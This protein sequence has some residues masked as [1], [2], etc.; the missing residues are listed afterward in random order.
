MKILYVSAIEGGKHTGPYYSVPNQIGAQEK[1]DQI[2]WVN[3]TD[4]NK[5]NLLRKDLYHQKSIRTFDIDKL[6]KPFNNPDLVV[7][8]EFFKIPNALFARK[9]VRKQIPYVIIPRSQM[10][11]QY[12][13]HKRFKKQIASVAL[14]HTFAKKA[15][16]VQFL[17]DKEL[18]D[19]KKFYDGKSFVVPNGIYLPDINVSNYTTNNN[20]YTGT[21][22]G[23]Y[24]I[25]QKGLDLL[26]EAVNL[27]RDNLKNNHISIQLYGPNDRTSFPLEVKEMVKKKELEEIIKVNGPV[28]DEQKKQILKQSDFFIH[29]SRFEGLPMSVLDALSFGVPC[30]VTDG[31]NMRNKIDEFEAGWGSETSVEGVAKAFDS[32]ISDLPKMNEKSINARKLAKEYSWEKIS[33]LSHERYQELLRK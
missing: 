18:Q 24:S 19:S 22:I 16:A 17:T 1:V 10:T 7:F 11:T 27:K 28:F 3:L 8:E 2:Y 31:S 33:V 14:F 23:R 15:S 13:M 20:G 21:F 25:Y 5:E 12:L 32:L 6:P 29:T 26:I 30:L 4:I 9:L